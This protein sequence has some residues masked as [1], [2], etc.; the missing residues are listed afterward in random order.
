M[1]SLS[2]AISSVDGLTSAYHIGA[3]YFAR[4]DNGSETES[5]VWENSLRDLFIEYLKGTGNEVEGLTRLEDAFFNYDS[6]DIPE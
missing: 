2:N 1:Q 5:E 4:L 6:S 3:S